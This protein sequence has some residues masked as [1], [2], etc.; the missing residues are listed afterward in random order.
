MWQLLHSQLLSPG[1]NPSNEWFSGEFPSRSNLHMSATDATQ[2]ST[3][4][5]K[6][7]NGQLEEW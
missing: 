1:E 4:S 5:T 2:L 6:D 7:D 3:A